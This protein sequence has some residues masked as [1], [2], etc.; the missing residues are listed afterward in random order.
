MLWGIGGCGQSII[1]PLCCSFLCT[2]FPSFSVG[3]SPWATATIKSLL[4]HQSSKHFSSLQ[5][6]ST[7]F[8][9]FHVRSPMDCNV[10]IFSLPYMHPFPKALP[11]WLW[12][13]AGASLNWL[14]PASP[15]RL[16]WSHLPSPEHLHHIPLYYC[17]ELLLSRYLGIRQP[18]SK[19]I[20]NISCL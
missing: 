13:S 4:Q 1:A 17:S 19:C 2:L 20:S 5:S 16:P 6:I 10:D 9:C 8:T 3:F 18:F 7:C 15:Q 12:G 14:C 11:W